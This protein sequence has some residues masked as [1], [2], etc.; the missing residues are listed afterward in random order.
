[1]AGIQR[2]LSVVIIVHVALF[3]AT[4]IITNMLSSTPY[5]GG[6]AGFLPSTSGGN[7]AYDQFSGWLSG[8]D[9]P[10]L[11]APEQKGGIV[12]LQWIVRGPLCGTVAIVRFMLS[13]LILKY[14]IID[15]IPSMGFGLWFKTVIHLVATLMHVAF[16]S[17]LVRFAI[18]AGIFSNV[19]VMAVIGLVGAIGSV[20]TLLNAGGAFSCG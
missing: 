11:D 15:L 7:G 10:G 4:I 9:R 2:L 16:I 6:S 13:A 20:A 19:Y 12:I 14:G 18:Q 3:G 8:A 5:Y 17:M 1:M